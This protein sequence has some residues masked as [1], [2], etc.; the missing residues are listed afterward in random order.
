MS[1]Y[2]EKTE[3]PL[4]HVIYDYEMRIY[5]RFIPKKIFY[6]R[7]GINPKRYGQL[8]RGEKE[9]YAWEAVALADFFGVSVERFFP[10]KKQPKKLSTVH[11]PLSTE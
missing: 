5:T 2:H 8:V 3:V 6:Q 4:T 1:K 7:T 9:M 11:R 10:P